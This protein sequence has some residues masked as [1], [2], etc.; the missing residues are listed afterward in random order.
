MRYDS[1]NGITIMLVDTDENFL[2]KFFY[3]LKKKLPY[4]FIFEK[5]GTRALL[6]AR[7]KPVHLFLMEAKLTEQ[8]S[9]F[10]TLELIRNDEKFSE[11]PVIF[12]SALRDK[13]SVAKAISLGVT[14]YL[15]KPI[16]PEEIL[17]RVVKSVNKFVKFKILYVD[18]D[19]KLFPRVA[20]IIQHLFP[21]KNEVITANSAPAGMEIISTQ[22]IN[23][24]IVGNN[25]PVVNGAR[26]ISM[27]KDMEKL[28]KLSV[29]FIPEEMSEIDRNTLVELKIEH[30]AEKPFNKPEEFI[31]TIMSALNV[32]QI[33][34]F[35]DLPQD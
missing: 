26:M 14:D 1:K 12:V 7:K 15:H 6:T 24:L 3:F 22:E 23:L 10:K 4:N 8:V 13:I 33:P 9:G 2:K 27:L 19:E 20:S 29:I 11:T 35:D 17:D 34:V 5:N 31:S 18:S 28:E 25:M 16:I 32:P 30:Y 21:Y